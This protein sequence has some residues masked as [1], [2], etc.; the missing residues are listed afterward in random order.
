M[1]GLK[2]L[3]INVEKIRIMKKLK[4]SL[5][6]KAFIGIIAT[7]IPI[8]ITFVLVYRQNSVYLKNRTL[9]TLTIIAEA[10]EGQVYQFLEMAKRRTQDFSSDG[11]IRTQLEKI[12]HGNTSAMSKLN[13]HLVRNKLS[14]DKTINTINILSLEG[15]VAAS[16]N[17]AEIG[18]D[19]SSEAIFLNGKE[20]VTIIEKCFGHC[21]LTE[22]A[23]SAPILNKDTGRLIG[24]IVNYIPIAELDNIVTGKYSHDLGAVSWDKG[25]GAWKTLEIYLVNR[26]KLMITKSIFVKDAVWKQV[27]DTPPINEGLTS[28]KEITGFYRDYRGVEVAGASMYVPTMK[29]ILLV[30]IDKSEVLSPIRRILISSLITAVVV[31]VMIV[32]LFISFM[33]RMVKPL[34]KISDAA[35]NIAGGNFD[36]SIPVQTSD[37]IGAL[38]ESFNYMTRHIKTRTVALTK[39]EARLAE[40]QQIAHLGSWEWDI[41]KNKTYESDEFYRIC[42]LAREEF[43]ATYEA[44]LNCVHPDDRELVRKSVENTLQNK[45]PYDIE[46]RILRKD[47]TVRIIHEK[48]VVTF[49]NTGRAIQM[50]GTVQD[51][52]EYKRADELR[53]RLIAIMEATSD[54]VAMADIH[55]NVLYYN[56]AARRILGI[57]EDEDIRGI[58]IPDTHPEWA[59]KVVLEKG[60]PA[61]IRDGIWSGETVFLRRDGAEI[62]VSQV[63]I[64][65]KDVKGAVN[66]LSTIARDITERKRIDEEMYL[67]QTMALTISASRNLH[68]ALVVVIQKIC[69]FTG[70]V[71]G[72]AWKPNPDGTLLERDHAY[73]SSIEG[74]EKFSVFTEGMTFPSGIGLPG[75]AWSAKQPV[76]VRDVTLDPK[77]LRA[78]IARE[79]GLKTGI[80]FPIVA[81]NEVVAVVVFYHVKVEERDEQLVKLVL[82]VLSQI[83]S[84]IK[85]KRAEEALCE[86]EEKLRAILDNTP[87]VVYVKDIRNK[88]LFINK[89]FEKLLHITRDEVKGKTDKDLWSREMADAFQVND[90]RVIEAKMPME[91][92]E[93][94][95]LDEE[96]HTYVSVKFPLFDS[97]G[98]IYAVCGISTDITERKHMEEERAKLRE[99]L[100]HVQKLESV[101]TLAGGIAHDFNNILTAIIGYG[102]LLQIEMKEGSASKDFVQKILKSAERAANLTQGLLAFSRKQVSNPRP[103]YLN[104]IVKEVESLLTRV[105]RED[106]KLKTTLTDKECVVMADVGQM[107]QVLMNLATNARDAMPKGGVLDIRTDIAEIDN[108][109]IKTHGYGLLGRYALITVSDTGMGIDERTKERIFEPFFT[110]KQ[111]GKGTGLGLVI[112]YGIVKQHNG[113]INVDSELGKGTTFRIYLPVIEH[114]VESSKAEVHITPQGGTE[115]ILVA[116]DE[117]D[118]RILVKIVLESHGYTVI[119]AVDG[120]DAVEKFQENKERV[121]LLLL[122]VIMPNKNGKEAYEAI[123]EL[124][125]DVKAVFMSGY[126]EDIVYKKDVLE[127]KLPLISKPVSPAK[128]LEKVREALDE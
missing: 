80:A 1:V 29:W 33:K 70:W 11:F 43:G 44:F 16:T 96:L 82:T 61:A 83:G 42:G 76:W 88:Y 73:Y 66:Y 6:E 68:D 72:E 65:H 3:Y 106:I 85:R 47:G 21:E 20:T 110:T 14:L 48:A 4:L 123:R 64:A 114:E 77:Y 111:V 119:E 23:I 117:E 84:I 19:F 128:I 109:F 87:N 59:T 5:K 89:Q 13:K 57:G 69:N 8:L 81:D 12:L 107:E 38:C 95:S 36:V 32:L 100:H 67:L 118:V 102:N 101:G 9:D 50:V 113:Y 71:Y 51:I 56:K 78:S 108:E 24:V 127:K 41:V 39:S 7:L 34:H 116:E 74:F 63:I 97:T 15:R 60:I 93:I 79:V 52:T 40:S 26:D 124:S 10:Y 126:S 94:A 22:I 75:R 55:G 92:E 125:P 27:V 90:R 49:G 112:V 103:V 104:E 91:F 115:T 35:K 18:R 17:N 105:V 98:A 45:K 30:E 86:S 122:D 25:K 53:S 58:R 37:E 99:Q 28:N 62:P 31:I 2:F 120:A 54:F 121:R 46:F